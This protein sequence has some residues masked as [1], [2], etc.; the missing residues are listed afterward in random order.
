VAAASCVRGDEPEL[1]PVTQQEKQ[2]GCRERPLETFDAADAVAFG[3]FSLTS[4]RD[5]L[6]NHGCKINPGAGVTVNTTGAARE[7]L[8][9]ACIESREH[10]CTTFVFHETALAVGQHGAVGGSNP[11]SDDLD[12]ALV[13]FPGHRFPGIG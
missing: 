2:E 4:R 12:V 13:E 3:E 9:R 11:Q 8:E 1:P 6:F 7:F 10:D 5:S